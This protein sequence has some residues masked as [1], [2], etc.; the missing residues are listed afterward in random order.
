M[1]WGEG[2]VGCSPHHLGRLSLCPFGLVVGTGLGYLFN[3]QGSLGVAALYNPNPPTSQAGSCCL[4]LASC[5]WQAGKCR[6]EGRLL[7]CSCRV[8]WP[9]SLGPFVCDEPEKAAPRWVG[10]GTQCSCD[11]QFPQ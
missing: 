3:S 10:G 6:V 7:L 11:F 2:L 5:R 4:W 1:V 8:A 9:S